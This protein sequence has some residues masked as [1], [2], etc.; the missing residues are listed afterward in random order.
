MQDDFLRSEQTFLL[1]RHPNYVS[2]IQNTDLLACFVTLTMLKKYKIQQIK[3]TQK[4][5][6]MQKCMFRSK[7]TSLSLC[8]PNP[9]PDTT[10]SND[11][12]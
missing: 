4:K 3:N 9:L 1:P 12:Q 7:Q 2:K 5:S 6:E 10:R 11:Q 8:H